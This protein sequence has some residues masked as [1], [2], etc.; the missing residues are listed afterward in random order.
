MILSIRDEEAVIAVIMANGHAVELVDSIGEF[1]EGL[2]R[3][4]RNGIEYPP[5]TPL[6]RFNARPDAGDLLLKQIGELYAA[7]FKVR[8][9]LKQIV[10]PTNRASDLVVRLPDQEF[11]DIPIRDARDVSDNIQ[12]M[13]FDASMLAIPGLG[14]REG[15]QRRELLEARSSYATAASFQLAFVL[16]PR[17][18]DAVTNTIRQLLEKIHARHEIDHLDMRNMF[19]SVA[20]LL[21]T[22]ANI[23]IYSEHVDAPRVTLSA[24]VDRERFEVLSGIPNRHA[25]VLGRVVASTDSTGKV[26]LKTDL[27]QYINCYFSSDSLYR[28][29]KAVTEQARVCISGHLSRRRKIHL[30]KATAARILQPDPDEVQALPADPPSED[31]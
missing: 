10:R 12:R 27:G 15:R 26:T 16:G 11:G 31:S 13:V 14:P 22:C 21:I 4:L 8:Y 6:A 3:I 24:A 7:K 25:D 28:Q 5:G 23:E 1:G 30:L 18:T 20:D 29:V 17:P 19:G 9:T 2:R